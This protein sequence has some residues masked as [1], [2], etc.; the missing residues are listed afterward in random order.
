MSTYNCRG[1]IN[2]IIVQNNPVNWI[3]PNGEWAVPV[4]ILGEVVI[5]AAAWYIAKAI[6]KGIEKLKDLLDDHRQFSESDPCD[7]SLDDYPA[8][9]DDWI[10][11]VGWKETEAGEKTGGRHRHWRGP[12]GETRRWDRES[13]SGRGP[14]WHDHRYPNEH[15]DPNR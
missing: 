4:V 2:G 14:H 3:D 1:A 8:N 11:P 13:D 7:K 6:G 9:P 10:P 15:I 12:N 5:I